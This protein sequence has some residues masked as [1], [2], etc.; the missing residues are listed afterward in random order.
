MKPL[1]RGRTAVN[2]PAGEAVL[3]TLASE[4]DTLFERMQTPEARAGVK[5]AF[6]ASPAELGRAALAAA[7]GRSDG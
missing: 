1:G 6:S 4:L 5:R 7:Q 3:D 2:T